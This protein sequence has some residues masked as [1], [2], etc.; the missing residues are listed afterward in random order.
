M[1]SERD[2][3]AERLKEI[4]LRA[5]EATPGPWQWGAAALD[6]DH[7]RPN[8]HDDALW[9][10]EFRVLSD[11]SARGEYS[12][13]IDTEGPDAAFIAHARDDVPW[14][15]EQVVSLRAREARLREALNGACW[16]LQSD[17]YN[18][19]WRECTECGAG[20]GVDSEIE[21]RLHK[22]GCSIG[23]ALSERQGDETT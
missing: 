14:L 16:A 9:G 13:D 6:G 22:P 1:P 21:S 3:V 8:G 12:P 11:G 10:G 20:A 19:I 17:G 15:I 2:A 5:G 18:K 4:A 23:A 7:S